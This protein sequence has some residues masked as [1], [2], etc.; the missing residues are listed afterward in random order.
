MKTLKHENKKTVKIV[1]FG[2]HSFA[3]VILQSLI[4]DKRFEIE[5]VITQPD[6]PVGR[7]QI[8]Q[9]SPV[10]ILAEEHGLEIE[11][12]EN[13]K[14]YELKTLN[15]ELFIVAQYG[16]LIP[17]SI[18]NI[19]K[20]GTINTHTSLLPK[21]RGASPI[22]SA[23]FNGDTK[24]GV[25][26]MLMDK[27]MDS[28]PILSQ[29]TVK[30]LPDETYIELDAKMAQIASQLL[31]D[32]IPKYIDGEIKPQIQDEAEVTF[33]KKLDRD[34]GKI[35]WKKSTTEIYNQYRAFTPWPGVWTTWN[36]KRL[37]FLAIKPTDK[38]IEAGQVQIENDTIYIGTAQSSL[39]ILELQL[40][41]KPAISSKVFINGYG[42]QFD[43]SFLK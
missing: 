6:K 3:S 43:K 37:K 14:N 1:F 32:T 11:Q 40:E 35:D 30:V 5:K 31:L 38:K 27:G 7:K 33:C 18:L 9:K 16:L 19:P 20:F 17:E 41:G 12:P 10:K 42:K 4:N 24:T 36:N 25:T 29:K 2:T 8:L 15:S 34:D 28:G 22:Q 13:L 21:Y 26:I 39:E 23:I